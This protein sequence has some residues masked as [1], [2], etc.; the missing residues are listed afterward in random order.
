MINGKQS[1]NLLGID[2]L[3]LKTVQKFK[4]FTSNFVILLFFVI[5]Q[6]YLIYISTTVVSLFHFLQS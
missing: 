3:T 5:F 4:Y 1:A 2:M 6:K